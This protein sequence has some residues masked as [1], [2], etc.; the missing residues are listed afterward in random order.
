MRNYIAET[1]FN[2]T[3]NPIS[4]QYLRLLDTFQ[5]FSYQRL[6]F[7]GPDRL[8]NVVGLFRQVKTFM[9]MSGTTHGVPAQQKGYVHSQNEPPVETANAFAHLGRQEESQIADSTLL[10]F[11]FDAF[12]KNDLDFFGQSNWSDNSMNITS[13]TQ[14]SGSGD[15]VFASGTRINSVGGLPSEGLPWATAHS[16]LM[17]GEYSLMNS[18]FSTG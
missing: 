13:V 16:G 6:N 1:T 17:P 11:D 12:L 15:N 3:Q 18:L 8:A 7:K 4:Q 2:P 5:V 10:G 14:A 9:R